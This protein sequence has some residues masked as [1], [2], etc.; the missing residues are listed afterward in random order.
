MSAP[1]DRPINR[2]LAGLRRLARSLRVLSL[3]VRTGGRLDVGRNVWFGRGAMLAAP[4]IIRIGSNVAIGRN[5]HLETNLVIG[6]DVLIS[7]SVA[8]VGNDHLFDSPATTVFWQGRSDP[9]CV[10][11][12]GDNLIGFGT[13]IVGNVTIGRGAIVGAGSVVT[14]DLPGGYVCVGTPARPLRPR[15]S[16]QTYIRE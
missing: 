8:V 4:D 9:S 7:S 5:F 10:V 6:D 3:R 16:D 13:R 2:R 1:P 15:Y 12:E 14:R 11:L